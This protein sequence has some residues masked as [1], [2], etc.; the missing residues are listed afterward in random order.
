MKLSSKILIFIVLC[1]VAV[2]TLYPLFFLAMT[3]LR[4]ANDY[5]LSPF[6]WPKE[7]TLGNFMVLVE[8]YGVFD[9][10]RN[11]LVVMA[12]GVTVSVSA[13]VA[14][15]FALV[16]LNLPLKRVFSGGGKGWQRFRP[17]ARVAWVFGKR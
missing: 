14:A 3:A 2:S 11:S 8:N 16:K 6:G 1:L 17:L 13:S 7:W 4:T 15:A 10:V 9:A 5:T 12:F